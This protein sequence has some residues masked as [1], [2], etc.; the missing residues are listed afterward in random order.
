MTTIPA[1]ELSTRLQAILA[2]LASGEEFLL[3]DAGQPVARLLA[4]GAASQELPLGP[5]EWQLEF[6]AW[7]RDAVLRADRYPPGFKLDD[8]RDAMYADP[9]TS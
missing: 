7:R 6:D 2:A 5:Q 4:A 1:V 9:E 3:T 8:S